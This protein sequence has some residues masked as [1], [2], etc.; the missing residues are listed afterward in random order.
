[1]CL[2]QIEWYDARDCGLSPQIVRTSAGRC[3]VQAFR[4]RKKVV[5]EQPGVDVQRHGRGRVPEHP[6]DRLDVGAGCTARLAAVC[7]R[8]CGVS[9]GTPVASAHRSPV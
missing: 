2:T 1:M 3:L 8:S 9:P 7:R 5:A 6:L 4:D